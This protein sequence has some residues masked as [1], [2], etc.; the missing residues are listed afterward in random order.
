MQNYQEFFRQRRLFRPQTISGLI[1]AT[2][3]AGCQLPVALQNK[4][5]SLATAK[6]I[7]ANDEWQKLYLNARELLAS[8]QQK[9]GIKLMQQAADNGNVSAHYALSELYGQNAIP[10]ASDGLDA[11]SLRL[12]HLRFA[13]EGGLAQAQ[14]QLGKL[15][16]QGLE[17][18]RKSPDLA[19]RYYKSASQAGLPEAQYGLG[20]IYSDSSS[21]LYNPTEAAKLWNLASNQGHQEA[22][23]ELGWLFY[24]GEGVQQSADK[25]VSLWQEASKRG[26]LLA[27]WGLGL[28]MSQLAGADKTVAAYYLQRA[29]DGGISQAAFP[30]AEMYR[31]GRGVIASPKNARRLYQQASNNTPETA[32]AHFWLG[33]MALRGQGGSKDYNLARRNLQSA[34]DFGAIPALAPLVEVSLL[35]GQKPK[36]LL[37]E[38]F[39]RLDE[40]DPESVESFLVLMKQHNLDLAD[41]TIPRQKRQVLDELLAENGDITM[42]RELAE[43]A[44]ESGNLQEQERWLREL[45]DDGDAISKVQLAEMLNTRNPEESLKID[46]ELAAKNHPQGLYRLGL[47]YQHGNGVADDDNQALALFLKAAEMG[48]VNAAFS[49]GD[50]LAR[51]GSDDQRAISLYQQASAGGLGKATL[52]LAGTQHVSKRLGLLLKAIDQ[53]SDEAAL[54]YA[55]SRYLD[56]NTSSEELQEFYHKAQSLPLAQLRIVLHNLYFGTAEQA[57]NAVINLEQFSTDDDLFINRLALQHL[58]QIYTTGYSTID[59]KANRRKAGQ[60]LDRLAEIASQEA[61]FQRGNLAEHFGDI[62]TAKKHWQQGYVT[63][64]SMALARH[65][66]NPERREQ[67]LGKANVNGMSEAFAEFNAPLDEKNRE[68]LIDTRADKYRLGAAWTVWDHAVDAERGITAKADPA[69]ALAW[70][71][72]AARLGMPKAFAAM[73]RLYLEANEAQAETYL[74]KAIAFDQDSA[75]V[76]LGKILA[77]RGGESAIKARELWQEVAKS[78]D[79]DGQMHLAW[80]YDSGIGGTEDPKKAFRLYQKLFNQGHKAAGFSLAN[81]YLAGRGVK[82]NLNKSLEILEAA[83]NTGDSRAWLQLGKVLSD[84][85]YSDIHDPEKAAGFLLL[86]AHSNQA[87]AWHLLGTLYDSQGLLP[88]NLT[89]SYGYYEKA[90]Y[91][92]WADAQYRLGLGYRNGYGGLATDPITAYAWL[93]LSS[94]QGDIAASMVRDSLAVDLKD[95]D[96]ERIK[97][98]IK[99][100]QKQ[101]TPQ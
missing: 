29:V 42:Q 33:I 82:T 62:A 76:T 81:M 40:N 69:A 65:E 100:L 17:G 97:A 85:Q 75:R 46:Q 13:A 49:A 52:R 70:Y 80:A 93:E 50:L 1:L 58:A 7:A 11:T 27:D 45:A 8:G 101:I 28:Y 88:Q 54:A 71:Q 89:L 95:G 37:S 77:K 3:L 34:Y 39:T 21:T 31:H 32:E 14:A 87:E 53:G 51:M 63:E 96:K 72:V 61:A 99:E 91:L 67:L 83:G 86:A 55:E 43:K 9:I 20:G 5:T 16:A 47:R 2:A 60:Y 15:Y 78:G 98:K 26:V 4:T 12:F 36:K 73:G 94:A 23:A 18:V 92:G 48:H 90:A 41:Y 30:L 57:K 66:N 44:Q 64:G 84:V 19:L 79:L 24:R 59:L 38:Y 10:L 68:W 74:R 35:Q 6:P 25:A 56:R 22:K